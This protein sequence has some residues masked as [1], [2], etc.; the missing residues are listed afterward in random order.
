VQPDA[1]STIFA[2]EDAS[3]ADAGPP[4]TPTV[5]PTAPY[6]RGLDVYRAWNDLPATMRPRVARALFATHMVLHFQIG[7]GCLQSPPGPCAKGRRLWPDYD[8]R[9][10]LGRGEEHALRK[11]A[12]VDD[13]RIPQG[14]D[15]GTRG[16][17][18]DDGIFI[19]EGAVICASPSVVFD[20]Y[21]F[22][23]PRSDLPVEARPD[24]YASDHCACGE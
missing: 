19:L 17:Q 8:A 24:S 23:V 21:W 9:C 14:V 22:A 1:S 12:R 18:R 6:D 16:M 3:T 2:P 20:E 4:P 15:N 11:V 5:A 10:R 13:I 7:V